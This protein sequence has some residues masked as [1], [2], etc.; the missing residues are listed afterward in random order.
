MVPSTPQGKWN[1]LV[2]NPETESSKGVIQ[3]LGSSSYSSGGKWGGRKAVVQDLGSPLP[4]HG[5]SWTL[6]CHH[7]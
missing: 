1:S 5:H 4:Q 7:L 3:G 2:V 6:L